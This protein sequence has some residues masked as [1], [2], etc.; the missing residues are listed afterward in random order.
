MS[1]AEIV[2]L[3]ADFFAGKQVSALTPT[4]AVIEEEEEK[5]DE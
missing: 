3:A 2:Q 5:D 4:E 1:Q